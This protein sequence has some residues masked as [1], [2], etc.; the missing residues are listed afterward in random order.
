MKNVSDEIEKVRFQ[1]RDQVWR[2]VRNQVSAKVWNQ[3]STKVWRQV[4][5]REF[6]IYNIYIGGKL[7]HQL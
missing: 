1:V 4:G 7:C 6:L 2:Q 3:V 5:E